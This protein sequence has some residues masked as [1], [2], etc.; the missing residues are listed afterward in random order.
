MAFTGKFMYIYNNNA[1]NNNNNNNFSQTVTF[2]LIKEKLDTHFLRL[3][4]EDRFL[5]IKFRSIL[6]Y[7]IHS[8]EF[9]YFRC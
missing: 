6:I 9:Q 4:I 8:N 3:K 7:L 1:N 2:Y 5:K